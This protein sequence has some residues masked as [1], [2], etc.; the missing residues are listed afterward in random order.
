[1]TCAASKYL[2]SSN[3]SCV[4]CNVSGYFISDTHCF[5]CH[6]TCL[7]CNGALPTN[8][9]TCAASTYLVSSNNSCVDCNV[10]G[11]CISG[12]HCQPCD[13]ACK[14]C[15]DVTATGCISCFPG[16]Y[17]LTANNS[18][19]SCKGDPEYYPNGIDQTCSLKTKVQILKFEL[20]DSPQLY[21]LSFDTPFDLVN[22]VAEIKLYQISSSA[23]P[24]NMDLREMSFTVTKLTSNSYQVNFLSYTE[25]NEDRSLLLSFDLLNS[26]SSYSY[27]ISPSNSTASIISDYT[28]AQVAAVVGTTSQ[29]IFSTT[30]ASALLVYL[31]AKGASTQLMRILQIMARINFMK[32]ININY[33]TPLATF[34]N[35]TDLGQFGLPNIFNKIPGFNN[36]QVSTNPML[37]TDSQ[38]QVIFNDYFQYSFS[39]VFLDN[40]GGIVFS[41]C[42]SLL[43][44]LLVKVAG[45]CFKNKNSRIK[46][47]LIAAEQSFE[48]SVLMTVLVSRYNYLWSALILNYAFNPI[49]GAYQQI[50]FGFA[51]FYTIIIVF[52]LILTISVS[53]YH[54]KNKAKLKSIRP[55]F[56]L[57]T[58]LCQEYRSKTYLGRIMTFWTLFFNLIIMLV[59][60]LLRKWVIVQ[61]SVLIVLNVITILFALPKNLFK[62]TA[63]KITV[64]GTELGFI[65]IAILSL[66][67][68]SL[69]N[70]GLYHVRLGLSWTTIGVNVA[71]IIFHILV[72]IAEFFR[73]RRA[74]KREERHHTQAPQKQADEDSQI[75]LRRSH[76]YGIS[77]DINSNSSWNR[78]R[79]VNDTGRNLK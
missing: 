32:L 79:Y 47:S 33:L 15:Y 56:D 27:M 19:T 64:I 63:T 17:L 3:N 18:C 78:I 24:P 76:N 23:V 26:N 9:I 65:I 12:P 71:I 72:K 31:K 13:S 22:S 40:Y 10:E 34:Y 37:R 74:K 21:L 20:R 11:Y 14:S 48:K 4:S 16:F 59:L 69:E 6:P 66:V 42:I 38:G 28:V 39:Q 55:F 52:I 73:L 60:E 1:M 8:C 77:I 30:A 67:M 5:E 53:F 54:G 46:K 43:L 44:Y 58:L 51:I 50:S 75:Q 49:H 35:F 70:S 29:I 36:S 57:V 45:K 62:T 68:Y 61:L 7:T 25:S 2:V 41:T